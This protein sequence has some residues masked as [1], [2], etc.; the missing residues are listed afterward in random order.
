MKIKITRGVVFRF[1]CVLLVF[2]A[3]NGARID[4]YAYEYNR[5]EYNGYKF[6][7]PVN[8]KYKISS[9][10]G[11]YTS[12]IMKYTETWEEKCDKIGVSNTS[13]GENIYFYGNLTVDNG[14]YAT[15]IHNSN[16]YCVIRF[17]KE[18]AN[19]TSIRRNE[20]IVHE[21]G[22]ALGLNHCPSNKEDMSVMR[23]TGFNNKAY[24]LSYDVSAIDNLY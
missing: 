22:H 15:S 17:Y 13:T 14:T 21:V 24:P 16:N 23:A 20:T 6:S 5:Y 18:F 19:T 1:L 8:V 9:S 12:I 2:F 10:I 11:Q 4:A 7:N 3:Y